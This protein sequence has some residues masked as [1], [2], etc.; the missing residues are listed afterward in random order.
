MNVHANPCRLG[1]LFEI[2]QNVDLTYR[3]YDW[4]RVDDQGRP[5]ELHLEK[6]MEA[7][8]LVSLAPRS[9]SGLT[10]QLGAA[11]VTALTAGKYFALERWRV[12]GPWDGELSGERFELLTV[13]GGQGSLEPDRGPEKHIDLT[14]G[15]TVLLPAALGRFRIEPD[16]ESVWLRSYVPDLESDIRK[17]LM[18]AGF[19]PEEIG[20]LA[21]T[22]RPNDLTNPGWTSSLA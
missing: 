2:Q 8:D 5:R 6:A 18:D 4:G 9:F 11:E 16:K 22:R 14:P 15:T 10:R 1:T 17:P 7:V 12:N 21:G 3:F 20:G 13:I 19:S